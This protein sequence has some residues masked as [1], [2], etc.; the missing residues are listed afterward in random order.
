MAGECRPAALRLHGP[1]M[2][3]Q[4]GSSGKRRKKQRHLA[5]ALFFSVLVSV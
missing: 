1:A 3:M 5:V 2:N 4:A